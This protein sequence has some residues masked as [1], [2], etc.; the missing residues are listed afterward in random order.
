MSRSILISIGLT[1]LILAGCNSAEDTTSS[2]PAKTETATNSTSPPAAKPS[3]PSAKEL[4]IAAKMAALPAPYNDADY[5]KGRRQYSACRSCHLV[6][7]SG[8]HRV[9]PNLHGIF[10]KQIGSA[11]NFTYSKAVQAV[12][13]VWTP[14]KLD[15]WLA[16]PKQFLPGNRM[17][18]NGISKPEKRT[19]LIAYLL[20]ETAQGETPT[21]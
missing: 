11:E 12:D 2:A 16:S 15:E 6:D 13:F 14:E 18:F 19:D 20:I 9:G 3:E 8:A 17:T 7:T 1:S 21:E 10:G 5:T 4:E